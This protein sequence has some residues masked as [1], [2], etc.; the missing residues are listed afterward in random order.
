MHDTLSVT[1]LQTT[2]AKRREE[3]RKESSIEVGWEAGGKLGTFVEG[4]GHW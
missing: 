4:T 1:A 2:A 3:S